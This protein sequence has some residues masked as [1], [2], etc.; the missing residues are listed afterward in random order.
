MLICFVLALNK[1][2]DHIT[3]IMVW[4]DHITISYH[5][6]ISPYHVIISPYYMIISP[7]H[8]TISQYYM[9]ISPYYMIISPYHII[10]SPYDTIKSL[11]HM[12]KSNP[13]DTSRLFKRLPGL[14]GARLHKHLAQSSKST[15][16]ITKKTPKVRKKKSPHKGLGES[17]SEKLRRVTGYLFYRRDPQKTS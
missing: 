15:H 9:S 1:S 13:T 14:R 17:S 4:Y 3:T 11:G 2:H 16:K 8:M 6:I 12:I 7:Y 10:K 5:I